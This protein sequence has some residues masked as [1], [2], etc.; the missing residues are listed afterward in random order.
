MGN[1]CATYLYGRMKQDIRIKYKLRFDKGILFV[2]DTNNIFFVVTLCMSLHFACR[3][4]LYVVTLCA[5]RESDPL[6]NL[7]R[8]ACYHY[9][10]G[11][12]IFL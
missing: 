11:A 8:V 3:Y 2:F 10:T 5:K 1:V 9:T 12:L 4:T 7:G 6:L